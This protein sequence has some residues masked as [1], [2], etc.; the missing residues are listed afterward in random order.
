MSKKIEYLKFRGLVSAAEVL[1]VC[2]KDGE[3]VGFLTRN[4]VDA[5]KDG[6]WLTLEVPRKV[7][8]IRRKGRLA[9]V[10][11]DYWLIRPRAEMTA[12]RS[13]VDAIDTVDKE[14]LA[15]AIADYTATGR[16]IQELAG[17]GEQKFATI[18]A[19]L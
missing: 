2:F 7:R 12:V 18:Q 16:K 15:E 10:R 5:E 11:E 19:C 9:I 14:A 13:V 6:R 4:F 3:M 8:A 17:L 1:A